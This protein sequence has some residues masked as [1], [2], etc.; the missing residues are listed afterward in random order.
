[1]VH[2]HHSPLT[3]RINLLHGASVAA[4]AL[5]LTFTA[6]QSNAQSLS[7]IQQTSISGTAGFNLQFGE[8]FNV[9]AEEIQQTSTNTLKPFETTVG[10]SF[11]LGG[12][13][14]QGADPS[15]VGNA[16]QSSL[17]LTYDRDGFLPIE[18][19]TG[20]V[21]PM[22]MQ[23]ETTNV[24]GN[25]S[26]T[27]VAGI[28]PFG[29]DALSGGVSLTN[30]PSNI[31]L[32]QD[33]DSGLPGIEFVTFASTTATTDTI[34]NGASIITTLTGADSIGATLVTQSSLVN[35]LAVSVFE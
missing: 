3:N 9:S 32:N 18:E 13:N 26:I 6:S 33:L 35:A 27:A 15:V 24:V 25:G 7:A 17:V 5:A 28:T 10:S 20:A 31:R 14:T 4:A 2:L 29:G 16:G 21:N 23:P 12:T 8:S 19:L 30:V 22:T 11:G 34:Q 1:M